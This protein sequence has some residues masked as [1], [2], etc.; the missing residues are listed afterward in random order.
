M[1]LLLIFRG[2]FRQRLAAAPMVTLL[3][4]LAALLLTPVVSEPGASTYAAA[5]VVAGFELL[6]HGVDQIMRALR[7]ILVMQ[8]FALAVG[9]AFY[10][11]QRLSSR[12]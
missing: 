6:T 7:P 11:F 3:L 8:G 5:I 12:G 4:M 10:L 2:W 9:A 1:G